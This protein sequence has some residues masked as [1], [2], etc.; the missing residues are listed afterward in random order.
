MTIALA[1]LAPAM[2]CVEADGLRLEP[3][4]VAHAEAMFPVLADPALYEFE[5]EPPESV[6]SLRRRFAALEARRSPNGREA[7][8]HWVVRLADGALI[9]GVQAT[10]DADGHAAIAYELG[11][12][13]WGR[14]FGT[15]AV[16]AML[17]ELAAQHGVRRCSAVL[18]RE[19]QRSFHLLRRLRFVQASAAAR[20]ARGVERDEWLMERVLRHDRLDP[21]DP[22]DRLP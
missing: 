18:K 9:G 19:N 20:A 11:S 6:D 14:G 15:R 2:R 10:V 7:W 12:A 13:W 4:C 5:H 1:A 21:S 3:Q 17:H 16:E 8:L 22:G